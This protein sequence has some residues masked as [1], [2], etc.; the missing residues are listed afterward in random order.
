MSKKS[1]NPG[2]LWPIIKITASLINKRPELATNH[3]FLKATVLANIPELGDHEHCA[4]CGASMLEYIFEFDCLDAVML[5]HMGNVVRMRLAD[6]LTSFTEANKVRV[7]RIEEATYAMKSRTTQMS[8]LGLIAQLR[9]ENGARVPG[10]WVI[11]KRGFDALR[12]RRVPKSVRV[13]RNRIEARTDE[14][15]TLSEA[16]SSH[17]AK[18]EDMLK[19]NKT[20]KTDYRDQFLGY[21][22]EDWY[23]VAGVHE[24][25][26]I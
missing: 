10:V 2:K 23:H 6:G 7:Q 21:R 13:W 25:N 8:K 16:F 18:V 9:G 20:P 22:P 12:G 1:Y 26:L 14:M 17:R 11:T 5:L 15:T 19:M 24:G 4:N 3:E